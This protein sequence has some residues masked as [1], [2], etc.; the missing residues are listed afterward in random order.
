MRRRLPRPLRWLG[1]LVVAAVVLVVC[2][3]LPAVWIETSCVGTRDP[4]LRTYQAILPPEHRRNEVD[5]W[6][7]Y[8]EWSIVHAYEDFAGVARRADESAFDYV[9]VVRGYWRNLCAVTRIAST[10]GEI[11]ADMRAMLHVIGASF[12]AEMVVKG[13]YERT[14]GALTA[15]VRGPERTPEDVFA[16]RMADDYATFLQQTP[17]YAYP[18][19]TELAKLWREVP[20]GGTS[21]WVRTIERRVSLTL[22][23]AVKTVYAKAMGLAAGVTPAQTT[24]RSI[25]GRIE[26][27]VLARIPGVKVIERRADDGSFVIETPRY[28]AFTGILAEIARAQGEMIEIAGN[29]FVFVTLRLDASAESPA[30]S[31]SLFVTPIQ[32]RPGWRRIGVSTRVDALAQLI[33]QTLPPAMEFEHVYDY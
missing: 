6:L 7:T 29:D 27:D 32:A 26:P 28:R 10:R 23:L 33:R 15:W 3:A 25:V 24:I 1:R 12:T 20:I 17:W 2:S 21:S 14:I 31:T 8:P 19:G 30:D 4:A 16:L 5:T 9:G 22:E 18:F 11:T 13:L